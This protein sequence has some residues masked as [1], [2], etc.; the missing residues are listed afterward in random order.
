MVTISLAREVKIIRVKEHAQSHSQYISEPGLNQG[1]D[2]RTHTLHRHYARNRCNH[3]PE[4]GKGEKKQALRVD[5][6][7]VAERLRRQ[8]RSGGRDLRMCEI[9]GVRRRVKHE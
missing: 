5:R 3:E 1:I 7:K 2:T 6:S 9:W 8:T 4:L